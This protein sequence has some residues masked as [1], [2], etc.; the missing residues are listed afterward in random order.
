MQVMNQEFSN[1]FANMSFVFALIV[2]F[3]HIPSVHTPGV[4]FLKNVFPGFLQATANDWFFLAAGFFFVGHMGQMNWWR[5][6]LRKRLQSLLVPYL[7]LNVLM[8]GLLFLYQ[9]RALH[10]PIDEVGIPV[11]KSILNALGLTTTNPIDGPLW[12][13]RSLLLYMMCV[14]LFLPI[15][16]RRFPSLVVLSI[17]FGLNLLGWEDA[18]QAKAAHTPWNFIM[19]ILRPSHL[20]YFLVGIQLRMVGVRILPLK[21]ALCCLVAGF[22]LSCYAPMDA[23]PRHGLLLYNM[24]YSAARPLIIIGLFSLISSRT[25]PKSLTGNSFAIYILHWQ[26]IMATYII[27]G[28]TKTHDFIFGNP[29]LLLVYWTLLV[30]VLI[31]VAQLIRKWHSLEKLFL[32]GR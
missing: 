18:I 2:V 25:W 15:L 5:E 13:V 30:A 9:G 1:R 17:L 8:L 20:F 21:G 16:K 23:T 27:C 28:K 31:G 11:W 19:P 22:A 26:M 4:A 32:G 3:I 7:T 10:Y 6:G 12:F 14:P 24:A 29:M